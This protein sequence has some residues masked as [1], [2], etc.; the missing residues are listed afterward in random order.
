MASIRIITR[1]QGN[2]DIAKIAIRIQH[3]NQRTTIGTGISVASEKWDAAG[4]RAI[5]SGPDARRINLKIKEMEASIERLLLSYTLTLGGRLSF[6]RIV[7][8]VRTEVLGEDTTSDTSF[9]TV[10]EDYCSRQSPGTQRVYRCTLS[11]IRA[12]QRKTDSLFFE[13]I[14]PDWL[15]GFNRWL[16]RTS[17]SQNYRNIHLRNIRTVIN[18]AIREGLTENYPFRHFKIRAQQ[19]A[20]RSLSV[21]DLRLLFDYPCEEHE[22]KYVDMFKLSFMLCG[23]NIGDM[24]HLKKESSGRIEYRRAK[25][26]QILSIKIEPEIRAIL[27]IMRGKTH[28]LDVMDR[29]T[30]HLS[31]IGHLNKRLKQIG[32]VSLAPHGRKDRSPLFPD[33]SSYWAR[34]TWA[35]IAADIDIPDAVISQGLGHSGENRVTDIYIRRNRKKVDIA[36]RRIIDWVLYG[37][38]DG[39][40]VQ[41]PGTP[42]YYGRSASELRRLGILR[43]RPE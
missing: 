17:R 26:G 9:L 20:K 2:R 1:T 10:M 25:T 24:C 22:R 14:T 37:I 27:R 3:K 18:Y 8:E 36:N 7:K 29:F 38:L 19:T 39:E 12:Y 11:R 32:P 28:L 34:H 41:Q 43:D 35:T 40:T 33:I 5:G 30:D 42:A 21:E 6:D 13:E 31:Y 15:N 4:C 23:M 16:S